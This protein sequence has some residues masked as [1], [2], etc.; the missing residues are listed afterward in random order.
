MK[1]FLLALIITLQEVS[2]ASAMS[3]QVPFEDPMFR[4]CV[5]WLLTGQ[6]G[7]LIGDICLDEYDIPSP[8]V[9]LCIRKSH[10]GFNSS[11]DQEACG[12]VLE[13]ELKKIKG[14]FIKWSPLGRAADHQ[15]P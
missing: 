4:R 13:E 8:S 11:T 3:E 5:N 14:G 2:V 12:I 6:R 10:T 1:P 9:F 7:A 15:A